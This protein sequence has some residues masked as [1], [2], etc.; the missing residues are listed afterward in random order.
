MISR[1]KTS[2]KFVGIKKK[3]NIYKMFH[4]ERPLMANKFQNTSINQF[5]KCSKYDRI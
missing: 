4:I 2:N 5:Q 3:S 1:K